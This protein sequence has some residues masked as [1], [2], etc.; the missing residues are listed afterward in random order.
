M[1]MRTFMSRQNSLSSSKL[2]HSHLAGKGGL[3]CRPM[4]DFA[5]ATSATSFADKIHH[6]MKNIK[7]APSTWFYFLNY[8]VLPSQVKATGPRGYLTKA[9][10]INFIT[11]NKLTKRKLEASETQSPAKSE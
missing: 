4:A 1:M 6:E 3:V 8:G 11:G 7:V 9:D 2:L 10:L 5:T